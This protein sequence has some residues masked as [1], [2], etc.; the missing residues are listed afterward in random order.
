MPHPTPPRLRLPFRQ[1]GIGVQLDK[2]PRVCDSEIGL[3]VMSE[4]GSGQPYKAGHENRPPRLRDGGVFVRL[5]YLLAVGNT[6][7]VDLV[8]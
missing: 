7:F 2:R 3:G 8:T 5:W 1:G 6:P 4:T